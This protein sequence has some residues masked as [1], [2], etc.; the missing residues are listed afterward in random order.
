MQRLLVQELS[1]RIGKVILFVYTFASNINPARSKLNTMESSLKFY[2]SPHSG[3]YEMHCNTPSDSN[4]SIDE[5][6][7]TY[8]SCIENGISDLPVSDMVW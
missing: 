1:C 2:D 5:D 4:F 3:V 8:L 7:W 6:V